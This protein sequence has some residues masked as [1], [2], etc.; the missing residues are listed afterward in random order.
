MQR[1]LFILA[2]AAAVAGCAGGV[3]TSLPKQRSALNQIGNPNPVDPPA[4]PATSTPNP[5]DPGS[6][7]EIIGGTRAK[8][9]GGTYS[10]SC[11]YPNG[12][13]GTQNIAV[14]GTDFQAALRHCA[15][16]ISETIGAASLFVERAW[17]AF[18]PRL[19]AALGGVAF[20]ELALWEAVGVALATLTAGE[21]A[22][23][24]VA[25]IVTAGLLYAAYV[26]FA[27]QQQQ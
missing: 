23:L 26:C 17:A 3:A 18:A 9:G 21:V 14:G 22:G 7:L 8:W 13:A 25:G 10:M 5:V 4:P 6:G 24:L 11:G 27:S 1:S 16:E 15:G 20:T 19:S 12:V 2:G